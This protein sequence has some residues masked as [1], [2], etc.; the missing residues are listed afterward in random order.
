M[1]LGV[2][3]N[4]IDE[5]IPLGGLIRYNFLRSHPQGPLEDGPKRTLH[6]QFLKTFLSGGERGSLGHIYETW[7]VDI[8]SWPPPQ[9][10]NQM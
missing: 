10:A 5:K 6:Q 9:D 2:P 7:D 4:P 8:G 3:E 1:S